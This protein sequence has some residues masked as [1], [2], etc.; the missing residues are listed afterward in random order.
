MNALADVDMGVPGYKYD[1][2]FGAQSVP[3]TPIVNSFQPE[4]KGQI[5]G[6]FTANAK[7][8]GIGTTGAS[9]QKSLNGQFD[10]ASTNLNLSVINIKSPL[11][12]T[13]V[14][15]VATIPDLIKNPEGAV[16]SLLQGL[17]GQTGTNGSLTDELSKSPINS[18]A[19]RGSASAGKVNLQQAMIQSTAFRADATGTVTLAQVLTNSAINI[20]VSV[21]LSQSIARRI[22]LVSADT[23]TN[24]TY[25]KLPD[26]LTETGTVGEPKSQINKLALISLA[27]KGLSG[28]GIG[29]T[30]GSIIQGLGFGA[31]GT[32]TAGQSTNKVG[33]LLQGL[34]GILGGTTATNAATTNQPAT[35]QPLNNLLNDLL[36]S[37]KK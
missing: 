36:N 6:T 29:G 25:V 33:S 37:K 27:A 1:L 23:P 18:I 7:I 9:L 4:R 17:T 15:V 13:V 35:N 20:P 21:S 8:K 19:A 31:A 3:L 2:T 34:G 12:K 22:N 24:A 28:S 14:N 32:N 11:I 26:F 30:A 5:G 16:G 10:L